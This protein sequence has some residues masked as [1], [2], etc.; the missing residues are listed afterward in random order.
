MPMESSL[1][2][3]PASASEMGENIPESCPSCM[4]LCLNS[5][6]L[7]TS[8]ALEAACI[9]Y[10]S[11]NFT[12]LYRLCR[13]LLKSVTFR[14]IPGRV[15]AEISNSVEIIMK[16]L[17]LLDL[18]ERYRKR[19]EVTAGFTRVMQAEAFI[20]LCTDTY[21][22]TLAESVQSKVTAWLSNLGRIEAAN[23]QACLDFEK[24]K[25]SYRVLCDP[26][27]GPVIKNHLDLFQKRLS[28]FKRGWFRRAFFPP[29]EKD[30]LFQ[31]HKGVY[32]IDCAIEKILVKL[33]N[34]DRIATG[35]SSLKEISE[36]FSSMEVRLILTV[37]RDWDFLMH[38]FTAY[39]STIQEASEEKNKFLANCGLSEGE[40]DSSAYFKRIDEI[41]ASNKEN[42]SAVS[43]P[44]FKYV[45]NTTEG[46]KTIARAERS[47]P[48]SKPAKIPGK[49]LSRLLGTAATVFTASSVYMLNTS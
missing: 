7:D 38:L 42:Y 29:Y 49:R 39:E 36:H 15:S 37:Q 33:H 18:M 32:N 6:A 4:F 46:F 44:V 10:N 1:P 34:I 5:D 48:D 47:T 30:F 23:L 26:L 8:I 21:I 40:S 11:R 45:C 17:L 14:V 12:E 41:C 43:K 16:A 13:I 27:T 28:I 9:K 24:R 35:K 2:L 25:L 19:P 31:K 20:Q 3:M 22:K